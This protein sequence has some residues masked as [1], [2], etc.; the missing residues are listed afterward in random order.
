M[1]PFHHVL[2]LPLVYSNVGHISLQI[3]GGYV[4]P[5]IMRNT[6]CNKELLNMGHLAKIVIVDQSLDS[7][8]SPRC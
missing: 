8:V 3:S 2:S 6:T 7:Q 4:D 1:G 5:I